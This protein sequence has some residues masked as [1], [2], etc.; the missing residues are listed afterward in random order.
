MSY[1]AQAELVSDYA[2]QQ[3][4]TACTSEQAATFKD[5]PDP[6]NA[7]LAGQILADAALGASWFLWPVATA[8]GFGD[9][10]GQANIQ[11]GQL[12]AA[13]QALWPTVAAVHP[14]EP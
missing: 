6:A 4:L 10:G 7:A 13:V 8:P 11:D 14:D 2:Y 12:L 3:R 9:A 5:D 1:L